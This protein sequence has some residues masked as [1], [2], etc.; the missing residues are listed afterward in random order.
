MALD[1]TVP[2]VHLHIG[3]ERRRIGSGGV[4][5]HVFPATGEPQ[6]P[7]PLA[8]TDDVHDAVQAA[9]AALEEWRGLA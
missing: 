3:D 5:E 4:H 6:G 7:V 8:G 2:D 9:H 1:R